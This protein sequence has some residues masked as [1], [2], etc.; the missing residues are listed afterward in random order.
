VNRFFHKLGLEGRA[1]REQS[2][3]LPVEVDSTYVTPDCSH[4]GII[5]FK[6]QKKISSMML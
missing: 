5:K 4:E 2:G 6:F 3:D 1:S